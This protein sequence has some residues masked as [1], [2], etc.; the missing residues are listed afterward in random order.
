MKKYNTRRRR[1]LFSAHAGLIALGLKIRQLKLLKPIEER[2]KIKQKVVRYRPVEKLFDAFI[3]ILAGAKGL[4]EVNKRVLP[5]RALQRAFGRDS[6]AEQST[7]QDT[8]NASTEEN[9]AQ[10]REALTEIYRKHSKGYSHNYRKR[11]LLLDVDMSGMPCGKKA[12]LASKGYFANKRNRRGRQLGRVTATNYSEIVVDRLFDG[13]TQLARS[14]EALVLEAEDVLELDE[15][16]R[17][18][19]I[20]RTDAGGGTDNEIN[21]ALGRGYH[22]HTKMYSA[23]RAAKLCRSVREWVKDT[24][25]EGREIGWITEPHPYLRSTV[26]VGIRA[27]KANGQWS[28]HVIVSTLEPSQLRA[29]VRFPP[30]LESNED[31]LAYVYFHDQ[32]GGGVETSIK[33]DHQGLGLTKRNK[34]RF[35]AQEMVVLLGSLAHNVVIWARD[36]LAERHNPF[37]RLGIMRMVRDVF[38]MNGRVTLDERGRILKISLNR[39]DPWA[40]P[41][42][43]SLKP[44][45][46]P[47]GVTLNLGQI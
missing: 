43:E 33:E 16:K 10:M 21:W 45:L 46:A 34:K 38:T 12:E 8:L 47:I 36:W 5:D 39:L 2:V 31:L 20:I 27:R 13:K 30:G 44:L 32:R 19:T 28:Y 25:V 9:V 24:K 29:F 1:S 42:K 3:A 35:L 17:K 18:N 22:L 11:P 26:Q 4:V 6:C 14:F 40:K 37:L 23:K 41:L 15:E 7:I